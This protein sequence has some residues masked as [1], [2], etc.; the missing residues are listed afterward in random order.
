[1]NI[2]YMNQICIGVSWGTTYDRWSYLS[3]DLPFVTFQ[4]LLFKVKKEQK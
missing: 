2:W 4:L 1:M 3:I